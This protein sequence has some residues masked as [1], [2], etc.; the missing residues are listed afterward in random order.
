M[1]QVEDNTSYMQNFVPLIE[2][3]EEMLGNAAEIIRSNIAVPCTA[4]RYCVSTCPMDISIP[5]YFSVYN[6]YKR[7]G[8]KSESDVI[9]YYGYVKA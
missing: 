5:D 8:S 7:F 3:E 2:E 1:E 9:N 6:T 4:C